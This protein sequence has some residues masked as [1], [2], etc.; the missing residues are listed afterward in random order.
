VAGGARSA[1]DSASTHSLSSRGCNCCPPRPEKDA[2]DELSVRSEEEGCCR[3]LHEA[4]DGR[5]VLAVCVAVLIP[6]IGVGA[7]WLVALQQTLAVRQVMA[8]RV[9]DLVTHRI[10]AS[11]HQA[12]LGGAI[13][14]TLAQSQHTSSYD[15]GAMFALRANGTSSEAVANGSSAG[16]RTQPRFGTIA[17][18]QQLVDLVTSL[19]NA[20]RA[21]VGFEN[22]QFQAV[23]R[24]SG[25]ARNDSRSGFGYGGLAY[26]HVSNPDT[27]RYSVFDLDNAQLAAQNESFPAAVVLSQ[28]FDPRAESW[29]VAA[30]ESAIRRQEAVGGA[31]SLPASE[32]DVVRWEDIHGI[33]GLDLGSSQ[34]LT[35]G[36][37]VAVRDVT[38]REVVGVLGVD[39]GMDS[40]IRKAVREVASEL[41]LFGIRSHLSVLDAAGGCVL[42]SSTLGPRGAGDTGRCR[43][44]PGQVMGASERQA[45]AAAASTVRL[46]QLRRVN[47]TAATV[48]PPDYSQL[49]VTYNFSEGAE[50][51]PAGIELPTYFSVLGGSLGPIQIAQARTNEVLQSLEKGRIEQGWTVTD[52]LKADETVSSADLTPSSLRGVASYHVTSQLLQI[53]SAAT[54]VLVI[55]IDERDVGALPDPWLLTLVVCLT[56]FVSAIMSVALVIIVVLGTQA[57]LRELFQTGRPMVKPSGPSHTSLVSSKRTAEFSGLFDPSQFDVQ[58]TPI[59]MAIAVLRN[60][61]HTLPLDSGTKANLDR[62]IGVLQSS[63]VDG[64]FLPINFDMVLGDG[65][66]MSEGSDSFQHIVSMSRDPAGFTAPSP[67][68]IDISPRMERTNLPPGHTPVLSAMVRSQTHQIPN[69]TRPEDALHRLAS[70]P[71]ASV[72]GTPGGKRTSLTKQAKDFTREALQA[73]A[74]NTRADQV[75]RSMLFETL[76]PRQHRNEAMKK[77][78]KQGIAS[79]RLASKMRDSSSPGPGGGVPWVR[80][81][82]KHGG[83]VAFAGS[84]FDSDS[85]SLVDS[86]RPTT[87]SE[88]RLK[89]E[90]STE[91][92]I[93]PTH[94]K[95][96]SDAGP[97]IRVEYSGAEESSTTLLARMSTIQEGQSGRGASTPVMADISD[98]TSAAAENEVGEKRESSESSKPVDDEDLRDPTTEDILSQPLPV[99]LHML[100]ELA[101]GPS[102]PQTLFCTSFPQV[103]LV[104]DEW[105]NAGMPLDRVP[106][107]KLRSVSVSVG[108]S[109]SFLRT[110]SWKHGSTVLADMS[111]PPLVES[112][113][114][115]DA[116]CTRLEQL[117][118]PSALMLPETMSIA[119]KSLTNWSW[120]VFSFCDKHCPSNFMPTVGVA[121]LRQWKTLESLEVP[122]WSVALFLATVERGY[123][124]PSYHNALHG[125]DAMHSMTFLL[126]ARR[127]GVLTDVERLAGVLA[128]ASHDLAHPGVNA[129]YLNL[130]T[131]QLS[132][133]YNDVSPLEAFHSY[134]TF[135]ILRGMGDISPLEFLS[136]EDRTYF[137]VLTVEIILGTD[138]A[139]SV[140]LTT[141]FATTV[142]QADEEWK[143][144]KK[145]LN[146]DL[147][148]RLDPETR[149]RRGYTKG[150]TLGSVTP[151]AR[152]AGAMTVSKRNVAAR[153][154]LSD[155]RSTSPVTAAASGW[156]EAGSEDPLLE[157]KLP[158]IPNTT[159]AMVFAMKC[160]DIG[161]CCKPFVIHAEWSRRV[162]FEFTLQGRRE[163]EEGRSPPPFMDENHMSATHSSQAGFLGF[164][165]IPMWKQLAEWI[166]EAELPLARAEE[167]RSIWGSL[168]YDAKLVADGVSEAAAEV[169]GRATEPASATR[170]PSEVIGS[171]VAKSDEDLYQFVQATMKMYVKLAE[172][173][174]IDADKLFGP[175]NL[176][177]V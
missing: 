73:Q 24:V 9:A 31:A 117:T 90:E 15:V 21:Y 93:R 162:V 174:D 130:N 45:T 40:P 165:A 29:Y 38:S 11:L 107:M 53:P 126:N 132:L 108:G 58:S 66:H 85:S 62:L 59:G 125:T 154:H 157:F 43:S 65:G 71:V 166:P 49:V 120:N 82:R 113:D 124:S 86:S 136:P 26:S 103:S 69:S 30:K 167:N 133:R 170:S 28:P 37:A 106:Q 151:A 87:T 46:E 95:H 25:L 135:E 175:E 159:M 61:R 173:Q 10:E 121:T 33:E 57:K 109:S 92:E 110:S 118:P 142:L 97:S 177:T 36:V 119:G 74:N 79:R 4:C 77:A 39:F 52:A 145:R 3:G 99:A 14:I 98:Q 137:R 72:Y 155:P 111:V 152:I 81:R 100:M 101:T 172:K 44:D 161:H 35:G 140:E 150:R 128:S 143:R 70:D 13:Q 144:L 96:S 116:M 134:S 112:E 18:V 176:L 12:L 102:G 168:T 91:K 41:F 42:F 55:A 80:T 78:S 60:M 114:P 160:A 104:I 156:S 51:H 115:R 23:S 27:K 169:M 17:T 122:E 16:R 105:V 64:A 8:V 2:D 56:V 163:R 48:D 67:M 139:R 171:G 68:A 141:K 1:V 149:Q 5:L 54:L 146:P 34:A 19:P 129:S 131:S 138:M 6:L 50:H 123:R 75:T 84:K 7:V 20:Q 164:V 147:L 76:I 47:A 83:R 94:S 127:F 158:T 148:Q 153:S 89:R 32:V 22:G 88:R 63:G